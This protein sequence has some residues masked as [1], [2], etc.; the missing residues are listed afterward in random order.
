LRRADNTLDFAINATSAIASPARHNHANTRQKHA[1]SVI[2]AELTY[3]AEILANER[4]RMAFASKNG[5]C[6]SLAAIRTQQVRVRSCL[7]AAKSVKD[8]K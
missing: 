8:D 3:I 6:C 1:T 7:Y 5:I 2:A 4:T